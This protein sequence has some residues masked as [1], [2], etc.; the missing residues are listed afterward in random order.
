MFVKFYPVPSIYYSPMFGGINYANRIG[1]L[2]QSGEFYAQAAFYLNEKGR[3]VK[4]FL[5]KNVQSFTPY[6]KGN[7]TGI[8]S[9][10][11]NYVTLPLGLSFSDL[12]YPKCNEVEKK[13]SVDGVD[14]ITIY[15]CRN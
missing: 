12:D 4:V 2:D 9:D 7:F 14:L 11:V 8:Y 1:L 3:D 10:D 5:P 6:F 13:F 15:K